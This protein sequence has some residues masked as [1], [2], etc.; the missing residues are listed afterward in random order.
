MRA[1]FAMMV[2]PGSWKTGNTDQ[3]RTTDSK[4]EEVESQRWETVDEKNERN[5]NNINENLWTKY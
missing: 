2:W 5:S 1:E 3:C 4:A